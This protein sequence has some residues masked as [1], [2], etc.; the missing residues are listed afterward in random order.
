MRTEVGEASGNIAIYVY[1]GVEPIDIGGSYGV[2]SMARRVIPD[3]GFFT[4][5]ETAEP[6]VLSGGLTMLP[7]HDLAGCPPFAALVGVRRARL[8]GA[9][10]ARAGARIPEATGAG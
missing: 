9:A 6:V 4:V 7:D 10:R 2:F 1:D 3:L 8:E 5:A